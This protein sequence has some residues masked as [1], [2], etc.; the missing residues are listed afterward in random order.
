MNSNS[1][2]SQCASFTLSGKKCSKKIVNGTVFCTHH[3]YTN[4]GPKIQ[5]EANIKKGS[6]C[7]NNSSD[8]HFCLKHKP[9][10]ETIETNCKGL[11]FYKGIMLTETTNWFIKKCK[12]KCSNEYCDTHKHK[13]RLEKPDECPI[14]MDTILDTNEIPLECGHWVHKECLKPTNISKCPMCR[15]EMKKEE[16]EY[17]FG[18]N[19][20]NDINEHYYESESESESENESESESEEDMYNFTD[21]FRLIDIQEIEPV[22]D[23]ELFDNIELLS[24]YISGRYDSTRL[25]SGLSG[26]GINFDSLMRLNENDNFRF[27]IFLNIFIRELINKVSNRYPN[28]NVD[29]ASIYR[30]SKHRFLS[31]ASFL[32]SLYVI[33]NHINYNIYI[34]R[35]FNHI[36][37]FE[38]EISLSI[39]CL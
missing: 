2:I 12:N 32:K 15:Q 8:G 30:I 4:R 18:R 9:K 19:I 1:Y 20:N 7:T 14:C 31:N 10:T 36:S 21:R 37:H 39:E 38:H 29:I 33:F 23:T 16:I 35:I 26:Y 27:N 25:V 17:I 13:Y 5:C 24:S 11:V 6:R 3:Q 22:D 34:Q 28:R